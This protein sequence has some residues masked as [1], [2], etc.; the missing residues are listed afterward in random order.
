[1][2]TPS[3]ASA[4]VVVVGGGIAGLTAAFRLK[5]A[6]CNVTVLERNAH[7]GG[8]MRTVERDGFRIDLAASFLS[9]CYYEMRALLIDAGLD[10]L[11]Q[12]TSDLVGFVRDKKIY[13]LRSSSRLDFLRTGLLGLGAK[14]ALAKILA[15]MHRA[16]RLLDWTDPSKAGALDVESIASYARR[17]GIP[18]EVMD[19]LIDPVSMQFSMAP[20]DELS[21]VN[22]FFFLH[23]AVGQGFFN[24]PDGVQFLP[25]AL[26]R[27]LHVELSARV[28]GVEAHRTGTTVSWETQDGSSRTEQVDGVVIATPARQ[29]TAIYHQFTDAQRSFLDG[30][31]YTRGV[32]VV[33]GLDRVPAEPAIWITVPNVGHGGLAGMILDHNKAPD[34]APAGQGLISTYWHRDW[35]EQHW[36]LDDDTIIKDAV[37]AL[38]TVIPE[39]TS[40]VRMAIVHRWDPYAIAWTPGSLQA[41][42]AFVRDF[43]PASRVQLAGDYFSFEC[44]NSSLASGERAAARLSLALRG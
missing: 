10:A 24:S 14:V 6:G 34:R 28:T 4:R 39:V 15:D 23:M 2:K 25:N 21:V 3:G 1:M 19:V 40:N 18:D 35:H 8:R 13:R 37:A 43:D 44:T 33:V 30:L 7:L 11:V 32:A 12:P 26:G 41:L 36:A 38:S 42:G 16:R 17:R 9:D 27:D 31:S 20:P 5:R 29:A 22:L